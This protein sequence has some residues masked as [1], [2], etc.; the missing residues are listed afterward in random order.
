MSTTDFPW[1][2]RSQN[3]R[4]HS[5]VYFVGR[6]ILAGTCVRDCIFPQP[7]YLAD[8]ALLA[9]T[10][11]VVVMRYARSFPRHCRH[12][13]HSYRHNRSRLAATSVVVPLFFAG[14]FVP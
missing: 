2:M 8:V 1:L 9:E 14:R 6:P 4:A 12:E 7:L 13:G 11:N 3:W 10:S 5:W